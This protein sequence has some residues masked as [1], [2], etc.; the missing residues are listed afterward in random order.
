MAIAQTKVSNSLGSI[1]A[2]S[3]TTAITVMFFMNDS[4]SD[5]TLSL[6]VVPNGGTGTISDNGIGK[7]VTIAAGD[8]YVFDTEK[9][10][11]SDTDEIQAVA[12]TDAVVVAT[13][14]YVSL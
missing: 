14:S 11:L 10:V 1:Y 3:G 5:V 7:A 2:S 4:G 8:T 6:A 12:S 13:V 9:M